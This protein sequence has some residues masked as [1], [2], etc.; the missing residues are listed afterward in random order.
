[1]ELNLLWQVVWKMYFRKYQG[2]N[3][4]SILEKSKNGFCQEKKKDKYLYNLLVCQRYI[5]INHLLNFLNRE[6]TSRPLS[7]KHVQLQA[8]FRSLEDAPII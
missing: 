7:S 8:A 2:T 4:D 6:Q 5:F 3:V 1:M